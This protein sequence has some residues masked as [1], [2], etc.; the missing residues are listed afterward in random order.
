MTQKEYYYIKTLPKDQSWAEK[1]FVKIWKHPPKT[2]QMSHKQ[3][4][5]KPS[6][7]SRYMCAL[8]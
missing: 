1:T 6:F 7:I 4:L 8:H 2:A 5:Q 3:I